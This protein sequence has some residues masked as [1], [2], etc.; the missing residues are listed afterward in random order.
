MVYHQQTSH[1]LQRRPI[2]RIP[3]NHNKLY[4][5]ILTQQHKDDYGRRNAALP[6]RT[7]STQTYISEATKTEEADTDAVTHI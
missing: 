5:H 7:A 3:Q 1:G 4:E 6:L 2:T